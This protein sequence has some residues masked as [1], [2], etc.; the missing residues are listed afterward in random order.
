MIQE[1]HNK[2]LDNQYKNT[3]PDKNSVILMYR[4]KEILVKQGGEDLGYPRYEEFNFAKT[5]NGERPSIRYG[6]SIGGESYFLLDG[7]FYKNVPETYTYI[8]LHEI[9]KYPSKDLVFAGATGWHL[10]L[11]YRHNRFCGVCGTK[12]IPD[13]KLRMMKCPDCGNM[14]FP[15]IQPAVIVGVCDKNRLLMTR[16]AGRTCKK[17]ALIAGFTEIGE[18]VEETVVREVFEETG[19]RVKNIT[20]YNSQPWGFDGDL[21]MGYFCEVD[22][23]TQIHMDDSELSAADWVKR[24]DIPYYDEDLSLTG[25]M[26]NYFRSRGEQTK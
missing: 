22:G 13:E 21:L 17:Y 19:L 9:R 18:S 14:V 2:K 16:Y 26:M 7:L 4:N 25:D 23:S 11:W 15:K 24:Q 12:M 5:G 8:P 10:A 3:V 6:F 1:L 20:Y